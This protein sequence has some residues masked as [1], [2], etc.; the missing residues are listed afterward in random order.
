MQRIDPGKIKRTGGERERG[1][2]RKG[3]AFLEK[4]AR[5]K[6]EAHPVQVTLRRWRH[7]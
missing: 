7:L 3:Y 5:N 6:R 4:T 2:Q 1:R